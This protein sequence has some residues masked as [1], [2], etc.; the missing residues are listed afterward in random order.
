MV[1]KGGTSGQYAGLLRDVRRDLMTGVTYMIPFIT[2]AGVLLALGYTLGDSTTIG[3]DLGT[4][5]WY[6]VTIGSIAL[7]AMVPILG[8]F[9]A[10][11]VADK[12]GLAP[13]FV[14]ASL[15]QDPRLV[16][17]T[18]LIFGVDTGDAVGGYLGALAVGLLAGIA[19]KLVKQWNAPDVLDPLMAVLILPVGVTVVLAPIALVIGVPFALGSTILESY[20]RAPSGAPLFLFGAILGGMMAVDLGG[21]VNKVAYVFAVG[22][23]PEFIFT[24]MAAVMLGGMT[25]PLGFALAHVLRP[26][27]FGPVERAKAAIIAGASFVTEGAMTYTARARRRLLPACIAGSAVAGSLSMGLGV[28]MPAP[29]GGLLVVPLANDPALFLACLAAGTGITAAVAAVAVPTADDG[30]FATTGAK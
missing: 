16:Q 8:G 27:K 7:S 5:P 30:A 13:G 19:A 25:P 20:L 1:Q 15:V 10:Y 2:I 12:P 29:H 9:V 14:L 22:L 11:G 6:L 21:P 3:G 17:A 26:S 4:L 28:S 23:L 18:G 24:P